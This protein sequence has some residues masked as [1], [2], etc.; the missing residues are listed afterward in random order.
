V[1]HPLIP[2]H[3]PDLFVLGCLTEDICEA[4]VHGRGHRVPLYLTMQFDA[5]NVYRIFGAI[6]FIADLQ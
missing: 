3:D 1:H 5:K 2:E 6:S 4:Q